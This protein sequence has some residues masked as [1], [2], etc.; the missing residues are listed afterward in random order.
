MTDFKIEPAERIKRLPPYLFGRLNALKLAKRQQQIDVIDLGM[1]NPSDPT[2]K[3]IVDKLCEAAQDPRNHRY[4][5][6]RGIL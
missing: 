2:P 4:S 6:S 1:G 5:V 3:V